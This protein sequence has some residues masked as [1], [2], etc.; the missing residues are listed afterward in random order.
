MARRPRLFAAGLLYHV[1]VRGNQRQK[2]FLS[3]QDYR[4]YQKR[5]AKYR[6]RY[7][8]SVHAYCLMPNHVHLLLESSDQPL[9]KL[10]QG[11]QQSYS[12]YFNMSHRKVG[13][14][15]Q[16]RYKAIICAKDEY[17]LELVRYIHLNPV[18]AG[19]V[20]APEGYRYS[21][22]QAYLESKAGDIIDPVKVLRLIGGKAGYR[23]FVREGMA[24][25][26]KEEYYEVE[27]QRFLGAEGF[28]DRVQGR[29]DATKRVPSK[30]SIEAIVRQLAKELG[31]SVD[32]LRS[33]E[34]GWVISKARTMIA[35]LMARRLGYELKEVA[36]Y[37]H[38]D[39]ATVGTLVS[40]LYDRMQ[41]DGEF[42]KRIDVLSKTVES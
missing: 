17:L 10:M 16:G 1:I 39:M 4:A 31:V 22:H 24:D 25:G 42:L 14:V 15:F 40:R 20:K 23:R 27:D 26:H 30:R 29:V 9:A 33:R 38:R 36:S 8:Y 37:L 35:Y 41:S 7:G 19:M 11:L 21:G 34:R 2:T 32:A 5:L 28:G 18:R 3:D 13:H 12:Q 6:E